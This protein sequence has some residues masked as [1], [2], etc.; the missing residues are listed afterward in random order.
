LTT[1][2][3]W[4]AALLLLFSISIRAE[5]SLKVGSHLSTESNVLSEIIL[6]TAAKAG[7][8]VATRGLASGDLFDSVLALIEGKIDVYPIGI[9]RLAREI[10]VIEQPLNLDSVNKKLASQGLGV[11]VP[12]GFKRTYS[13]AVPEEIARELKLK[14]VSDLISKAKIRYG[15]TPGFMADRGG[16]TRLT[17]QGSFP[18]TAIVKELNHQDQ[19]TAMKAK[20]ID[21]IDVFATD[22]VIR[23]YRLILLEDDQNY[24]ASHD[25]VLL[26]RL[27][28]AQRLPNVWR[29]ILSL[30]NSLSENT[31]LDLNARAESGSAKLAD[32]VAH[33]I[34]NRPEPAQSA[35]PAARVREQTSAATSAQ[36]EES[37][38]DALLRMTER[39]LVLV[40]AG[41]LFSLA[42]GIPLGIWANAWP[43]LGKIIT[44][45]TKLIG[46][47]PF[48]ALLVFCVVVAQG[49]GP[50][51]AIFALILYGLWPIA[52]YTYSGLQNISE[53]LI[54]AATM[55]SLTG[56]DRLRILD[57]PLAMGAIGKGIQRCAV[58]NV[59]MATVAA[60]IGSGG[61]GEA[62]LAGLSDQNLQQMLIGAI[63]AT[64]LALAIYFLFGWVARVITPIG[65]EQ[66]EVVL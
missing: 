66:P 59:G 62:I 34:K 28:V 9:D 2:M 20:K 50:F 32:V 25:V 29:R 56:R 48:L 37:L 41:L 10:V 13:L 55:Q 42:I 52:A 60:F 11:A 21:A 33:W 53:D 49:F 43:K 26:H 14:T 22:P 39:H 35:P 45:G 16:F 4:S 24:F 19:Q 36:S 6:Q 15:F 65:V 5:D 27:D 8:G 40:F 17:K 64:L 44:V 7:E 12:L 63:P 18:R 1:L 51:P 61:Y 38:A 57:L 47:A 31:L 58:V 23:K 46:I 3:R 30:E 54:D